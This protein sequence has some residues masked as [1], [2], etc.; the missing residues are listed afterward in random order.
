MARRATRN[1]NLTYDDLLQLIELIK[2]SSQFSEF[3]VKAGDMEV[4]L[5]RRTNAHAATVPGGAQEHP[6]PAQRHGHAGGGEIVVEPPEPA[7]A[8]PARQEAPAGFPEGSVVVR[9]PMV[10]TFYRAPEPGARPFVEVGQ[11]VEPEATVCIIEVMKLM[12]S[13]PAGAKGVVKE[14]LVGD[15]EPVEYGQPLIVVFPD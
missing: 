13:I 6:R 5:R 10:G 12:N 11:R 3:H 8:R 7:P 14:I 2:S 4:N 15:A 1:E 9:S